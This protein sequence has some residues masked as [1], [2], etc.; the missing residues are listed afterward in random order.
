MRLSEL[1]KYV[2]P[3]AIV[4][5]AE[6]E[7]TGV[8]ID[9]RKIEKGHLFVAI[10]G[11][12]TDGHRF[13]PKALELGAVAVLCEDLPEGLSGETAEH[14]TYVQVAST[15]A[16]VGPVATVFYGEPSQYLK[17]VGVTG[18]NGKTTIATLLYNM[19]RKFGHKF[20]GMQLHRGRGYSCRPY[21][22]RPY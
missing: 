4:G 10:K 19:F 21:D 20:Y 6:V 9:S 15:E 17:L 16:A 14:V 1:L 8:N 22:P 11:T 7:I 3:I 18:T 12:Q 5:N 2:K 13:I